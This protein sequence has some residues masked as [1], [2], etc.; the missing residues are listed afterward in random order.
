MRVKEA[1][2]EVQSTGA[3]RQELKRV[4]AELRL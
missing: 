4:E 2:L 1:Q 3:N